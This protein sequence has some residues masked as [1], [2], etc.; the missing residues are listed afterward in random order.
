MVGTTSS[1]PPHAWRVIRHR[2]PLSHG[3]SDPSDYTTKI[4][5]PFRSLLTSLSREDIETVL[6]AGTAHLLEE[7][8]RRNSTTATVP[9]WLNLTAFIGHGTDLPATSGIGLLAHTAHNRTTVIQVQ[10]E[11]FRTR[12]GPSPASPDTSVPLPPPPRPAPAGHAAQPPR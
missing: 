12:P 1:T 3:G 11:P 4:T 9:E 7:R 10:D 5:Q 2:I 8:A 6:S